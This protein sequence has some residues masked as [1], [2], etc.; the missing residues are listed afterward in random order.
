MDSW[1]NKDFVA[2]IEK[3]GWKKI[4]LGGLWTETCIGTESCR[5]DTQTKTAAAVSSLPPYVIVTLRP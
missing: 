4:L 3:T 1:D 2:V 5:L